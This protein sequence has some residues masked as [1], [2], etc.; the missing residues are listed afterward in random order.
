MLLLVVKAQ[1]D[2]GAHLGRQLLPCKQISHRGIHVTSVGGD[3]VDTSKADWE[4]TELTRERVEKGLAEKRTGGALSPTEFDAISQ[5]L[6]I[7]RNTL[8]LGSLVLL[9]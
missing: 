8:K 5:A 7:P 9:R 6:G 4:R 2:Q 3:L 1:L